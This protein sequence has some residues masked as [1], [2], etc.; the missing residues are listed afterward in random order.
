MTQLHLMKGFQCTSDV[1]FLLTTRTPNAENN[2]FSM[3]DILRI[4]TFLMQSED[5][6]HEKIKGVTQSLS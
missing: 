3:S 1:S 5:I 2:L 6:S 4:N